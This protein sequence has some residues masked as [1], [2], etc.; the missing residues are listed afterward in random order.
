MKAVYKGHGTKN[1]RNLTTGQ[2]Y[3]VR[4]GTGYHN[5]KH[6]LRLLLDDDSKLTYASIQVFMKDWEIVS[7]EAPALMET[8]KD[9]DLQLEEMWKAFGDIPMNPE[10]E[11]MEEPFLIFPAG[12][13]REE[14]WK[15]FDERY[16]KGI[17]ALMF[18]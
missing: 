4:F 13:H 11:E 3:H 15:W 7:E 18:I 1:D 17:A 9:R 14:I 12:T 8:L 6:I 16:S 10:T 5:G 2:E